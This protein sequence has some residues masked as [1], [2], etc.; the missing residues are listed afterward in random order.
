MFA[1]VNDVKLL[2][3]DKR[4]TFYNKMLIKA[5]QCYFTLS[6]P[7]SINKIYWYLRYISSGLLS[8]EPVAIEMIVEGRG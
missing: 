8:N 2:R 6:K 3:H 5:Y 4:V 7:R 1:F